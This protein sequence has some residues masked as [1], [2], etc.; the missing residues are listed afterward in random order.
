MAITAIPKG[1]REL[2]QV[3][4]DIQQKSIPKQYELPSGQ[5]PPKDRRNVLNV[6]AESGILT[7]EEIRMTEQDASSLLEKYKS[8]QWTVKQV[9]TAFLKKTTIIQQLV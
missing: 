4:I 6:P 5:V 3:C 7:T 8:G 2:A 9:V 1:W